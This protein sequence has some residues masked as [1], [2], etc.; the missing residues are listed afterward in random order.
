MA[1]VEL[2]RLELSGLWINDGAYYSND[3]SFVLQ[4]RWKFHPEISFGPQLGFSKVIAI[5]CAWHDS[6][7]VV[8]SRAWHLQYIAAVVIPNDVVN[9]FR[10]RQNERHFP[11]DIWFSNEFSWMKMY[12]FRL[13]FHWSSNMGSGNGLAP[14]RRQAI[15][16][17]NDGV[18]TD[19]YMRHSA[20]MS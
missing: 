3:F 6:S 1:T 15:I 14:T 2:P 12:E 5:F 9:T 11:D 17:T 8:A 20:S 19:A 4:I 10:P 7:A 13:T 18:I 16:W